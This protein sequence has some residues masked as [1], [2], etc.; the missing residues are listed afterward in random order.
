MLGGMGAQM[1]MVVLGWFVLN[2]TNSPF[3]VGLVGSS[4]LAA[5]I[6][7]LFAGV[8]TDKLPRHLL[9]AGVGFTMSSLAFLLLIFSLD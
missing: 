9:L 6:L 7:A 8:V 3:L 5:N 1:E 4:R 2:L